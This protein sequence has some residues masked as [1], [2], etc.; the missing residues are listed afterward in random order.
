LFL[1]RIF[2]KKEDEMSWPTVRVIAIRISQIHGLSFGETEKM[3][4]SIPKEVLDTKLCDKNLN[5]MME[6]IDDIRFSKCK[7]LAALLGLRTKNER[8]RTSDAILFSR[9][10]NLP[11]TENLDF[12]R[13]EIHF[14][15]S[16]AATIIHQ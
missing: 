14:L 1:V 6:K 15:L 13:K 2:W 5:E 11:P 12:R 8:H 9:I 4:S 16:V 3:F 7:K 10:I